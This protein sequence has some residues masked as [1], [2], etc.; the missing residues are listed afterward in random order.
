MKR[1]I[2]LFLI[3][4]VFLS[5]KCEKEN[6]HPTITFHNTSSKAVYIMDDSNYPDTLYFQTYAG[7]VH[8]SHTN[9]VLS[10][11]LNTAALRVTPS[12]WEDVIK[13]DQVP[14]DTIM[15]FVFDAEHIENLPWSEITNNYMVLKRYELSLEDLVN[16]NWI[17]TYP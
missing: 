1:I 9:K 6:C 3:A 11:S 14:S 13:G 4:F 12:C 7:L 5:N 10:N 8:N 16:L 17:I 15:I 2:I